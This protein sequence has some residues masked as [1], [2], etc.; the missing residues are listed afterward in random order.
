V[1]ARPF[2]AAATIAATT[3]GPRIA[4]AAA[5]AEHGPSEDAERRLQDAIALA[6]QLVLDLEL[7]SLELALARKR[8]GS[9][10]RQRAAS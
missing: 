4:V 6:K 1:S 7:A 10:H 2:L 9:A 8:A 3:L 5:T